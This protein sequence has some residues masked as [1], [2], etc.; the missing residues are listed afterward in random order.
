MGDK[1]TG[2][3]KKMVRPDVN[4]STPDPQAPVNDTKKTNSYPKK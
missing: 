4:T 3:K 1:R 2:K